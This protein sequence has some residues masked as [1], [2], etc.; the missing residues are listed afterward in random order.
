MTT[1]FVVDAASVTGSPAGEGALVQRAV[2]GRQTDSPW[3]EQSVLELACGGTCTRATGTAE[4]VLFVLSGHGT[5]RAGGA[6]HLLEP[7]AGAYISPTQEYELTAPRDEELLIV[8]VR[9]PDSVEDGSS[10]A[11]GAVVRRLADQEAADATGERWFRIVSDPT[12]GLRSATQF[13]GYIPPGRAPDH[14]HLY[15]EVIYVLDGEGRFHAVGG[16]WPL[17]SGSCI[18]LPAH[19][20]HCLENTGQ[21]VL[22]VLAV[23]RP[24]GS[25]AAAYYPEAPSGSANPEQSGSS[26]ST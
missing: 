23:L 14:F 6:T 9:I 26:T 5:L 24:A 10:P 15:D 11:R 13:V 16:S 3:L 8:S 21:D 1:P 19:T 7:E 12:T 25:P 18:A 2:L 4:E 17:G 20:V 22:R